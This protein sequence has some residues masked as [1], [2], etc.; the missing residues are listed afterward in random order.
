[1]LLSVKANALFHQSNRKSGRVGP[2]VASGLNRLIRNEP[3]VSAAPL[4]FSTGVAP[5]R[6][7]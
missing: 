2:F 6:D 3:G 5:A 4:I 1:M 7:V